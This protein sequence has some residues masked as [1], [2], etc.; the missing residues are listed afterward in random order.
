MKR[1]RIELTLA[2]M[3]AV[4]FTYAAAVSHGQNSMAGDLLRLHVVAHSDAPHDQEV[5]LMVR[6][7]VL[8]FCAPLLEDARSREDVRETMLGHLQ[9]LAN[10]TQEVL[11][12]AGETRTVSVRLAE[13]YYPTRDYAT[14][15][16]PAGEYL[17]LRITIGAG[18]GRNWWCVVFPPL[19]S[20]VAAGQDTAEGDH[21][22]AIADNTIELAAPEHLRE[23]AIAQSYT[24]R[25][26]TA[27]L[28][29]ALRHRLF[30]GKD[31]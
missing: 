19:C 26:K 15:S 9:A 25:F 27:E 12:Q 14:F 6:D 5:K 28:I 11:W 31:A 18:V 29:G 16:L 7:A 8:D 17:G 3:L 13:E 4:L 20:E 1:K 24:L 23:G 22:P 10:H 2:L 30:S 21:A